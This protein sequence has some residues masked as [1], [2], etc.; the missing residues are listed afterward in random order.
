MLPCGKTVLHACAEVIIGG[1]TPEVRN[2]LGIVGHH[3]CAVHIDVGNITRT[4]VEGH[5][6]TIG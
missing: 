4:L 5:V 2:E 3:G 1:S 6:D